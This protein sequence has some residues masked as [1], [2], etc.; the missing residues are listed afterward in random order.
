MNPNDPN[1]QPTQQPVEAPV[2][3]PGIQNSQPLPAEQPQQPAPAPT[4]APTQPTEQPQPAQQPVEQPAQPTQQ[5]AQPAS[6]PAP[7][8]SNGNFNYDAYLDSLVGADNQKPVEVPKPPTQQELENDDQ[9]LTKFFGDLVDTAVKKAVN[10]G[11]KQTTIRE[12]ETRAWNDVFSKYPEIKESKGLRDTIHNIRIGAYQRG[13]ALS[14]V[15]VADQLIGDL[16]SQYKKGVNDTNVQTTVRESQPLG[17][18]TPTPSAAPTV[19][20]ANLHDGGQN[21]AIAELTKLIEQDKI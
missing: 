19:N 2:F 8:D 6:Q 17:G 20:L 4:E 5:A 16:H 12:A 3:T 13:Q 15:Q 21:A 11:A 7:T 10:E 14:P 1:A 18:G 9:A